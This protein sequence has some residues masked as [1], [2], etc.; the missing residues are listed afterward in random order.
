M[1]S[2]DETP[3]HGSEAWL[4]DRGWCRMEAATDPAIITWWHPEH[5]DRVDLDAAVAIED[6]A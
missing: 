5:R 4:L 1:T 3:E 2:E 6:A